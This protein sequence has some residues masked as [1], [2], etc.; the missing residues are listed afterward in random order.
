MNPGHELDNEWKSL[1]E[2]LDKKIYIW[3]A[4]IIGRHVF[5]QLNRFVM[6]I[7][8]VAFIDN[9]IEK[10][11]S[12]YL[13]KDVLSFDDFLTKNDSTSSAIIVISISAFHYHEVA[14]QLDKKEF[15]NYIFYDEL[16]NRILPIIAAYKYN[17]SYM[18]SAQIV[19]TERC[20][21]KCKKCAHA[22]YAVDRHANDM[23]INE[24]KRTADVFFR[25]V[26][27]VEDFVLIGGEPLLYNQLPEAV[28]YIGSKYSDHIGAFSIITNGTIIPGQKL[29]DSCKRNNIVFE[30][31]NYTKAIPQLQDQYEKLCGLLKEN[32]IEYIL[33][34]ADRNWIDYGFDYLNEP[35]NEKTLIA[36]FDSCHT[37]CR[38]VRGNK[39]FFCIQAS[40]VSDNL[41]YDELDNDY[42]DLSVLTGD[43]WK[44]ELL[45]YNL[46]Y[47]KKGYL[48]MCHRCHG[49][50]AVHYPIPVA[51]QM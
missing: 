5:N 32:K 1:E 27:Y 6:P 17:I 47:S 4:G 11:N 3:G 51:E 48:T 28:D 2:K 12:K 42:L 25:R 41:K 9:S 18:N 43:N 49:M 30:I 14:V 50:D 36:R 46:G 34:I 39:L 33:S 45:E 29:L 15:K 35:I 31:S 40:T 44:K 37:P 16:E 19:V 22:C 8:V 13:G 23:S 24:L 7:D 20:T 38:E 21:L 26:D 10:Q